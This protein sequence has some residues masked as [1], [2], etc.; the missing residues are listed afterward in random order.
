MKPDRIQIIEKNKATRQSRW[1]CVD[2]GKRADTLDNTTTTKNP[3]S[4]KLSKLVIQLFFE[5]F[6]FI[7]SKNFI[8]KVLLG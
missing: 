4:I 1:L 3:Y 2:C 7:N 8:F 6:L 5:F